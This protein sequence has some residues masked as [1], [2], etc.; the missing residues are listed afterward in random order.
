MHK[1]IFIFSCFI[2][3]YAYGWYPVHSNHEFRI[4]AK[5][6]LN[7]IQTFEDV[8]NNWNIEGQLIS[9][10]P[11]KGLKVGGLFSKG[12]KTSSIGAHLTYS[13]N[14]YVDISL[15]GDVESLEK[16]GGSFTLSLNLDK[17]KFLFKP[18]LQVSE[19]KIGEIGLIIYYDIDKNIM[20]HVGLGLSP[21][22]KM[23]KTKIIQKNSITF[24]FG[25][26]FKENL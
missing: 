23:N 17:D 2:S 6:S 18:F 15:I 14:K 25:T 16:I 19:E 12:K 9:L 22:I 11:I 13:I 5:G 4:I 1:L 24:I 21:R 26:V 8:L 20:F 7:K 10:K 3:F